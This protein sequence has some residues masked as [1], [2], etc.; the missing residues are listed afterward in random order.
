MALPTFVAAGTPGAGTTSASPGIPA[1]MSS[2]QPMFMFAESAGGDTTT[3]DTAEWTELA[4]SPVRPGTAGTQLSVWWRAYTGD[5]STPSISSSDHIESVILGFDGC[6]TSGNPWDIAVPD[7][8]TAGGG[9]LIAATG[10]TTTVDDCLVVFAA[11]HG[12]DIA[13]ANFAN[14]ANSDLANIIELFNAST[15][16]G[17]GG[18]VG[19]ITGEKASAGSIGTTTADNSGS[20]QNGCYLIALKPAAAG[21]DATV[22]QT[23]SGAITLGA[24]APTVSIGDSVTSPAGELTLEADVPTASIGDSVTSPAGE[25]TLG[26]DAPTASIG[27]SVVSPAG[28]LTLGADVPTI[29]FDFSFTAPAGA[30]TL[31]GPTAS[32]VLGQTVTAP[33]GA[34]VLSGDTPTVK[35]TGS[36]TAPSGA[37][38]LGASA[39]TIAVGLPAGVGIITLGAGTPTVKWTGDVSA[40]AANLT[41]GGYVVIVNTGEEAAY[42]YPYYP[43]SG[44]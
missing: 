16:L 4:S 29:A 15:S 40:P 22:T 30:L 23:S 31:G 26:A 17:D 36:V 37:I 34:I 28:G 21:G 44:F 43:Y 10:G 33:A 13:T 19:V 25:I 11:S 38:T 5:E 24:N 42:S 39:P 12:R 1:G 27:D 18:G 35:Y 20:T 3:D 8:D 32:V 2:G 9:G 6:E 7:T 41:L 14:W